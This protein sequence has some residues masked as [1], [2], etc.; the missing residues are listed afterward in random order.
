M[1]LHLECMSGAVLVCFG[2][3]DGEDL[4]LFF[5]L[6]CVCTVCIRYGAS[7]VWGTIPRSDW[8]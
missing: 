2:Q 5:F 7:F 4:M 6:T 8:T 3:F 1:C